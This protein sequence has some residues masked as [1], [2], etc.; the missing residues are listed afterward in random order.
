[1][2]NQTISEDKEIVYLKR[3]STDDLQKKENAKKLGL[4]YMKLGKIWDTPSVTLSHL[5]GVGG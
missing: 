4:S 5:V 1:M 3:R 2:C